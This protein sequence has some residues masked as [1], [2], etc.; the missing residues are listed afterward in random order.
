MKK[1]FNEVEKA[2]LKLAQLKEK[3]NS[4]CQNKDEAFNKN[5]IKSYNQL[6]EEVSYLVSELIDYVNFYVYKICKNFEIG[7]DLTGIVDSIT[8]DNKISVPILFNKTIS[9]NIES[10][11]ILHNFDNCLNNVFEIH[12]SISIKLKLR[13]LLSFV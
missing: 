4:L 7:D 5:N 12:K 10:Y 2:N 1:I 8:K 3:I 6:N 9:N 13:Y 11:E